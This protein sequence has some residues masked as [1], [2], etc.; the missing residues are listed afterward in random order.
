M[1]LPLDA[2]IPKVNAEEAGEKG[3]ALRFKAA[4]F[5]SHKVEAEKP[6]GLAAVK[7]RS[8]MAKQ[9]AQVQK[10]GRKEKGIFLK[11]CRGPKEGR[12]GLKVSKIIKS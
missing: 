12:Q 9:D 6:E 11:Y 10:T 1:G 8:K 2:W 7:M 5:T 4:V 3:G